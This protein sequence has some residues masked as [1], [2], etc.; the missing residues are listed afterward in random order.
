MIHAQSIVV[1][2]YSGIHRPSVKAHPNVASDV[3]VIEN[4]GQVMYLFG[5]LILAV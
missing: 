4:G 3:V 5:S 2:V 1:V